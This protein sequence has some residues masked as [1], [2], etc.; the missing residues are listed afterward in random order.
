[1]F[2]FWWNILLVKPLGPSWSCLVFTHV[3]CILV[4]RDLK[5]TGHTLFP[6]GHDLCLRFLEWPLLVLNQSSIFGTKIWWW[7][8]EAT[9]SKVCVAIMMQLQVTTFPL[10][11]WL[12]LLLNQ[13]LFW[14]PYSSSIQVVCWAAKRKQHCRCTTWPF[15]TSK[16][17]SVWGFATVWKCWDLFTSLVLLGK[18]WCFCFS[19]SS[20]GCQRML[21]IYS[22]ECFI[23]K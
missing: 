7:G 6:I 17:A 9:L 20:L 13:H 3:W 4:S 10:Y 8:F 19:C 11:S 23:P 16:A 14:S 22:L 15:H 5:I 1:M 21:L 2:G 12:N 18:C